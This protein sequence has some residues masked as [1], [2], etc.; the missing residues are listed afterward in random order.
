MPGQV[1]KMVTQYEKQVRD[2]AANSKQISANASRPAREVLQ[3]GGKLM[4]NV[5][6]VT[7]ANDRWNVDA[8]AFAGPYAIRDASQYVRKL[9]VQEKYWQRQ[10]GVMSTIIR[11]EWRPDGKIVFLTANS[12]LGD[13]MNQKRYPYTSLY[14]ISSEYV[15]ANE[16]IGV[17]YCGSTNRYPSQVT[18]VLEREILEILY[19][20]WIR[21]DA[22]V[23]DEQ[24]SFLGQHRLKD[25]A[26]KS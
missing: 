18:V 20:R 3:L 21:V 26:K 15:K 24:G 4:R 14:A 16:L 7:S 10:W 6:V 11:N 23:S 9:Q 19:P 12:R 8:I 13:I 25:Q 2:I 22:L 1:R 17:K 5:T